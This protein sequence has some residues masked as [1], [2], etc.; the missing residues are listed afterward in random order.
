MLRVHCVDLVYLFGKASRFIVML[1]FIIIIRFV[2]LF[3]FFVV[4]FV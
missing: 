1:I 3:V 2:F 4:L